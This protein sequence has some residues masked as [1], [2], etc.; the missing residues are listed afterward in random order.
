MTE[1]IK[2]SEFLEMQK[3]KKE[4]HYKENTCIIVDLLVES[5]NKKLKSLDFNNTCLKTYNCFIFKDD[6]GRTQT[7][8]VN[9]FEIDWAISRFVKAGWHVR[10]YYKDS[11]VWEIHLYTAKTASFIAKLKGLFKNGI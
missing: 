11:Y 6:L 1:P 3:A 7:G 2:P 10:C 9:K 5:I 8:W 4:K